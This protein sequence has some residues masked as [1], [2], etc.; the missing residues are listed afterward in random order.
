MDPSDTPR[1]ARDERELN[2]IGEFSGSTAPTKDYPTPQECTLRV[3]TEDF[4]VPELG[5]NLRYEQVNDITAGTI[6]EIQGVL[7]ERTLGQRMILIDFKGESSDKKL[8][9]TWAGE[10]TDSIEY[11]EI[12]LYRAF[13]AHK[14]RSKND[15]APSYGVVGY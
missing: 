15:G 4:E 13:A 10:G 11:A 14:V 1:V 6:K 9:L 3:Y 12:M 7:E 2:L 8:A 5:L